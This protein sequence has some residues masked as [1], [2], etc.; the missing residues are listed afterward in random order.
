MVKQFGW[1]RHVG[2][3]LSLAHASVHPFDHLD[4]K[5][6]EC[7]GGHGETFSHHLCTGYH[8]TE[9]GDQGLGA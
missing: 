9:F 5:P 7:F 3:N 6:A 4:S 8:R 2:E 1:V